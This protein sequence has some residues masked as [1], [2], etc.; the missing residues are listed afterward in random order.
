MTQPAYQV[1]DPSNGKVLETFP[2]AS[3]AEIEAALA[4][5]ASGYAEWA[6][7]PVAERAAI[8]ARVGE[9]FVERAEEL[10]RLASVEMGKSEAEAAGEAEFAGEIFGYYASNGPDLIAPRPVPDNPAARVEYR[11]VG[12]ILGIM[13]WNYPYYQVARF[14]APNLIVGNTVV[15]KHAENCPTSALAIADIMAAAG[16]P[17]GVYVNVF[18][19]HEQVASMIADPRVQGVSLTGSERAGAAVAAEAGRHLKKVV[20]ELG[21]SDPYIVLDTPDVDGAAETAWST[22]MENVGQACNSN[23]RMIVMDDVFD[24]FV[25]GLTRRALE[26]TPRTA[27]GGADG[28][29]S[30]MVSRQAAE[31]LLAQVQDAVDKGATLHAGGTLAD[32]PGA[33]FAPAVLTG[34]TPE[35]RAYREELF[36]PV[37]VVYQVSSDEDAV[38][39]ANA[40]DYGLGGAVW[41][42]DEERAVKVASRLEVGMANV[43]TPAGEGADLPFGGTKRSG[44]G[45]ELGPLGIEEFVNKRLF[46][47]Q[48]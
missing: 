48:R 22:R 6:V 9:L 31:N 15:L 41:S 34:V 23:K 7:R 21:G 19:T 38:Q 40:V 44:F 16:V 42:S 17:E 45:R 29:Y 27:G 11:P 28:Q 8:A 24:E 20:L 5:A 30:P 47:I 3:D 1:T 13:P 25:S 14:A 36:G 35:M 10:S 37:A 2:P 4:S 32:G 18:A 33:F 43:N 39:L 26:M 12:T 46:Y